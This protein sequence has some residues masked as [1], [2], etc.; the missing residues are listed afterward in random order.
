MGRKQSPDGL[1]KAAEDAGRISPILPLKDLALVSE[2]PFAADGEEAI[3]AAIDARTNDQLEK[4]TRLGLADLVE[5]LGTAPLNAELAEALNAGLPAQMIEAGLTHEE[6]FPGLER[7]LRSSAMADDD[8]PP[9]PLTAAQ[10]RSTPLMAAHALKEGVSLT[11]WTGQQLAA[12]SPACALDVSAFVSVEGVELALLHDTLSALVK[13]QDD[14]ELT[15]LVHGV[16]A[17]SLALGAS[18]EASF[19][20]KGRALG[21]AI[22]CLR[23]GD[24]ISDAAAAELHT[25]AI[26]FDP[27]KGLT[28]SAMPLRMTDES[29]LPASDSICGEIALT[30]VTDDGTPAPASVAA[31]ALARKGDAVADAFRAAL[32][33]GCNLDQLDGINSKALRV[34]GF[35]DEAIVRARNALR[36]GLPLGAA[37]S[38]WVLG[39]D[40]ISSEL[41]LQPEAFD[42]DGR[43]LL[44]MIGFSADQ[45]AAAENAVSNA[46]EA[47]AQ[48]FF[49]D[50]GIIL[51][52]AADFALAVAET[53]VSDGTALCVDASDWGDETKYL[54]ALDAGVSLYLRALPRP[55]EGQASDRLNAI[56]DLAEDLRAE[57]ARTMPLSAPERTIVGDGARRT[58]LPD[59]RKGYIQKSTVGGHKV[60]LHTGEFDDGALGEIFIDMH[61][62]GA[63]FRSMMNNFAIAVSLGLQYGVPL[64]EYVDA[65]VFTRFEPAGEVTGNDRITKATSILDYIFRELAI[66]YLRRDDLAELGDDVSHDGLGRGLKDGTREAPQPLPDEAVQ[67]IS[68]G[69]SRGQLPDNIV[70]LERK[71]AERDEAASANAGAAAKDDAE[72]YLSDPCPHCSSFTL[73]ATGDE[74]VAHCATCNEPTRSES[75]FN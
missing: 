38:R 50:Q 9:L 57:E 32:E 19:A 22:S 44:Q 45:I 64:D 68:R 61:K 20:A 10:Y 73:M 60:Y 56:M 34:R 42:T 33:A 11:V 58:R 67:F 62:E 13:A 75:G 4:T 48:A 30:A 17:A 29:F 55:E 2:S 25:S 26:A 52:D 3:R 63:A 54:A 59:R 43:P 49:K 8:Q 27:I 71:R 16:A 31:I 23:T 37:F 46:S 53:L 18:D 1:I 14:G 39:D 7:W 12:T 21:E 51:P 5:Q 70:I 66:S 36:E 40:V 65:F 47:I 6:G 74:R 15:L 35:S 24:P 69:F 72:D 41:K 28:L